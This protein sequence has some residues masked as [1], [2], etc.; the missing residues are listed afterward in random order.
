MSGVFAF[1]IIHTGG[2]F[3]CNF[4]KENCKNESFEWYGDAHYMNKG[5]KFGIDNKNYQCEAFNWEW[6]S[7]LTFDYIPPSS[8]YKLISAHHRNPE[9]SICKALCNF[10]TDV[11]IVSSI[12]DPLL[13]I[14]TRLWRHRAVQGYGQ[15]LIHIPFNFRRELASKFI[16]QFK[17]ILKI[18]SDRIFLYSVDIISEMDIGEKLRLTGEMMDFCE[19]PFLNEGKAF[20]KKWE[21]LGDTSKSHH[22]RQ[23]LLDEN[24]INSK[25]NLNNLDYLTKNFDIEFQLLNKDEELKDLLRKIGYTDLVW[26]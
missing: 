9:S 10:D 20:I 26:Y 13:P 24:F 1:T 11:K 21:K 3:L 18:P 14:H 2:T 5:R 25:N 15:D 4:F 6:L 7:K 23:G 8:R 12:R 16:S 17:N 19:L 22:I